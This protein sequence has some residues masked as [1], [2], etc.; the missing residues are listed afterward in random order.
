MYNDLIYPFL[1]GNTLERREIRNNMTL[2]ME[3]KYKKIDKKVD[4]IVKSVVK[5]MTNINP[6]YIKTEIF[7]AYEYTKKAHE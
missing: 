4:K 6:E 5:Y 2:I 3:N 7:K 1:K